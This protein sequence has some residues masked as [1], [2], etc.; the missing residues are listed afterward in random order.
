MNYILMISMALN[1]YL[2]IRMVK[3]NKILNEIKNLNDFVKQEKEKTRVLV[4]K[5][6][7]LKIID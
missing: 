3:V 1:I 5:M 7:E 2:L 4:E 6:K